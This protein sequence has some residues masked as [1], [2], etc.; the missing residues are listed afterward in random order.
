M[1]LKVPRASSAA[2]K[3]KTHVKI[4]VGKISTEAT[5]SRK[6]HCMFFRSS[7]YACFVH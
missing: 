1:D 2:Y 7:I 6:T 3:V 5:Q 4:V